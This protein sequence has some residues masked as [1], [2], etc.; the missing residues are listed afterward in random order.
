MRQRP[1]N[2][3]RRELQENLGGSECQ[4]ITVKKGRTILDALP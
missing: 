4:V 1:W 3:D 2:S